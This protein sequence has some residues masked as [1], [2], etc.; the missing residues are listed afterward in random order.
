MRC[1][2]LLVIL[3]VISSR[4]FVDVRVVETGGGTRE[5]IPGEQPRL[6][7]ITYIAHTSHPVE[8][9][10]ALELSWQA[11]HMIGG[12]I[13]SESF[14]GDSRRVFC[15]YA[16][17]VWHTL[18]IALRYPVRRGSTTVGSG[19]RKGTQIKYLPI[20]QNVPFHHG[21]SSDRVYQVPPPLLVSQ[22]E[23]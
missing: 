23:F 9:T 8:R 6:K 4:G 12:I 18:V 11:F 19:P 1:R 15:R 14:D 17:S 22:D 16:R 5:I 13:G 21:S 10:S 7:S 20:N 2:V 3:A